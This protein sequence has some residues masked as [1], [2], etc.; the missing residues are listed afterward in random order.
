MRKSALLILFCAGIFAGTLASAEDQDYGQP[1]ERRERGMMMDGEGAGGGQGMG[2]M[3][4]GKGMMKGGMHGPSSMVALMDGSIVVLSGS[5]LTKYDADLNV[6]KEVEVKGGP[7]PKE[8]KSG[9]EDIPQPDYGAVPGVPAETDSEPVA[10]EPP[11][12]Q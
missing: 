5:K 3:Q 4:G 11:A 12:G 7:K 1:Q 6:V 2:G 10:P 9:M 8:K